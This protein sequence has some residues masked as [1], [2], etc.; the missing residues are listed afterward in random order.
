[1]RPEVR[2]SL[3]RP[4]SWSLIGTDA[5]HAAGP[6]EPSMNFGFFKPDTPDEEYRRVVLHEF[7]HLLGLIHELQSPNCPIR[8]DR[9]AVY[10][11]FQGPPNFWTRPMID[12]NYLTRYANASRPY[13]PFDAESIMT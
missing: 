13:R 7:G 3:S 2:I 12:Q 8:W 4:G 5:L 9:E 6:D 1:P 10:R 11:Y